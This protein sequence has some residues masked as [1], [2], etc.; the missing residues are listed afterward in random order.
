MG[1]RICSWA[2]QNGK[3]KTVLFQLFWNVTLNEKYI[4]YW[5]QTWKHIVKLFWQ[6]STLTSY[7]SLTLSLT[8][9]GVW[10]LS[11]IHKWAWSF[12]GLQGQVP[13]LPCQWLFHMGTGWILQRRQELLP[14]PKVPLKEASSDDTPSGPAALFHPTQPR[15]VDSPPPQHLAGYF[16][17]CLSP[18]HQIKSPCRSWSLCAQDRP[19]L[20]T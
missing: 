7:K 20:G 15:S 10:V 1:E 5:S 12:P 17:A 6:L 16:P 11:S 8:F 2:T 19:L 14:I 9:W 3:S 4:L 13:S 18:P